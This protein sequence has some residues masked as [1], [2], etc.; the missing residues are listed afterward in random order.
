MSNSST[1]PF[2]TLHTTLATTKALI[3]HFESQ[4]QTAVLPLT[5]LD[6]SSP[7]AL[8]IFSDAGAVLKAQTT[9]LA[10]LV[11]NEPFSPSEITFIL[12]ALCNECI[13]ALVSACQLCPRTSYTNFLHRTIRSCVGSSF[14]SYMGI[15]DE[16]PVDKA[17]VKRIQRQKAL[18]ST[19]MI[20]ESL[21]FMVKLGKAGLA[22][23][24]VSKIEERA[25]LLQ[26]AIEELEEWETGKVESYDIV[27]KKMPLEWQEIQKMY[28]QAGDAAGIDYQKD[29][30]MNNLSRME[31]NPFELPKAADASLQPTTKKVIKALKLIALL[32]PPIL[33]RRIRRF[34]AI[35]ATTQQEAFPTEEQTDNFDFMLVE[36][37]SWPDTADE[38]A[39][40]LYMHD[41]DD[42]ET[43]LKGLKGSA[44][45]CIGH[46]RMSWDGKED[47]FTAWADKW[48][49]KLDEI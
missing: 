7:N 18:N 43:V 16:I 44:R 23:V 42:V 11:L 12:K 40:V 14:K 38:I 20:W 13:P 41:E 24:A 46:V 48:L 1:D 31:G 5:P 19:G 30:G 22:P 27:E 10:L 26:D 33:K 36:C 28:R 45:K 2:K 6:P 3:S 4:I 8:A 49:V 35:D 17:G 9:K 15:L 37:Q 34:P 39:E 29:A 32:Y 47:E 21:D 25:S